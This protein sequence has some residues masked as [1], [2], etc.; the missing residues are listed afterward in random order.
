MFNSSNFKHYIRM[1][2]QYSSSQPY[3]PELP[4]L[5]VTQY[6]M[7]GS[8]CDLNR[9]QLNLNLIVNDSARYRYMASMTLQHGVRY[10][11]V[12]ENLILTH[13]CA[14]L[15]AA[16]QYSVKYYA[17]QQ[18]IYQQKQY[19]QNTNSSNNFPYYPVMTAS[20]ALPVS[21]YSSP[22]V[23]VASAYKPQSFG[24]NSS[25][26]NDKR[27]FKRRSAEPPIRNLFQ[28]RKKTKVAAAAPSTGVPLLTG[29][30]LICPN[31]ANTYA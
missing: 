21:N 5:D 28:H 31:S 25:V 3:S 12:D 20:T 2:S 16:L 24:V 30:G 27:K 26:K 4:A 19:L 1:A 11:P 29:R 17:E 9:L 13:A 18:L 6:L 7:S 10:H 14:R 22:P 15:R 23:L 8:A